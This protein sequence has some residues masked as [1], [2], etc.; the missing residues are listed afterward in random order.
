MANGGKPYFHSGSGGDLGNGSLGAIAIVQALYHRD[1]T[2]V[3]QELDTNIVNA[4]LFACAR[5]YSGADGTRFD[6]PSLDPE[7]L[8]LSARYGVYECSGESWLCLAALRDADWDALTTVIPKLAGDDR[9]ATADARTANDPALRNL[10]EGEF[11]GD[12]ATNWFAKL[13]A[14]GVPCEVSAIDFGQQVFDDAE[15]IERELVV[16]RDGQLKHGRV[17]MFGRLLNFSDTKPEIL[18]PPAEPGQHSREILREFGFDDDSID[19]LVAD[20]A[21]IEYTQ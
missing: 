7:L 16:T 18:G 12:S 19:K 1:K 4:G 13:D 6:H 8:G 20:S 9:F 17:E 11:A 3:G 10:L 14:A 5:V 21:V 15:M 2:G